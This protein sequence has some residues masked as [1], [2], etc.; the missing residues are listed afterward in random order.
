MYRNLDSSVGIVN[1]RGKALK[2]QVSFPGGGQSV[3]VL[4]NLRTGYGA[5]L[6]F[7]SRG[8]GF[9]SLKYSVRGVH[10]ITGSSTVPRKAAHQLFGVPEGRKNL[11]GFYVYMQVNTGSYFR[12]CPSCFLAHA[13]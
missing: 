2:N 7:Y 10:L 8:T 12:V 1:T 4:Q 5:R 3:S 11:D 6:A 9:I 13:L